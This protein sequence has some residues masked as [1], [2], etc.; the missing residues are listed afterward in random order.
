MYVSAKP[1]G[2]NWERVAGMTEK[3]EYGDFWSE[4]FDFGFALKRKEGTFLDV[5]YLPG[6]SMFQL[7]MTESKLAHEDE[8]IALQKELDYLFKHRK[9]E[10]TFMG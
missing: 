4:R 2:V 7:D 10:N 6:D 5:H 3:I 8:L 9:W 1:P